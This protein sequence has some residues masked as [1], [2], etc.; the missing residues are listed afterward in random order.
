MKTIKQVNQAGSRITWSE[1]TYRLRG[2][3]YY[4][5]IQGYQSAQQWTSTH[6]LFITTQGHGTL[7]LDNREYSL[8]RDC[9]YWFVP[10]HT[11]GLRSDA[12]D[13]IEAYLFYFD[14]YKEVE[15][16]A[17]LQPLR[18]EE[19]LE[20]HESIAVSSVGELA[21][22]CDA[23]VRMHGSVH[24]QERFRA[25]FAF[26]ELLYTLLNHTPLAMSEQSSPAIERAKAYMDL[27]YNDSLS[28]EQL[29]AIAG[30][31]PKYF[32]DLFKKTY[33]MSSHDYLTE[34]RMNKAKE[35][36]NRSGVKLRD[37]A[38]QVGYQD[39]FYFS[40]KFKQ[41]VGVSPSVYMRSRKRKIAAYG[42]GVAGYLL[43]L[44]IIPYA[45]P[46]HPK[47][48]KYY[49]DQYRY[50]IP[51]HLSAYRVNEHWA[52]NIEK[53]QEVS[54]D[55]IVTMDDL[56]R[57]EQEQLEQ[58]GNICSIPSAM[59]WRDQL[60]H[61]AKLLGE[62]SDAEN[63]LKRYDR[64]VNWI[65][66][67]LPLRVRNE[68][69]LF[70]RILRQQIFAYCNRGIAEVMF[71]SLQLKPAFQWK[72]PIYNV[73]MSLEQLAQIN[74]DRLLVNVCQESET[75]ASWQQLQESWR[76]QQLEAVR[77]QRMHMIHTDP[78]VE[79]SPIAM[80]RMME[81]MLELLSGKCP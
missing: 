34:L 52:A 29:G 30:V 75:L 1:A 5:Q 41:V 37:I 64:R 62:D 66:E 33:G 70:V 67:Q 58:M 20:Q 17:Q 28:I 71:G 3:E 59:N 73:E 22:H 18:R 68:S 8:S 44:N 78:W 36:L 51:V 14:M 43:A 10:E 2:A 56:I 69:L 27:H 80:E 9:A 31:S 35:F 60:K 49:Y 7:Q 32:V 19:E 13:G 23:V 81:T 4:K 38:H 16:E 72:E 11:F 39:E 61:T 6:L 48:T 24:A 76:W 57:E 50:D 40:R 79:Y 21:L 65:R 53:L 46:L 45:A 54:P 26:Q 25:Q 55:I 47:W 12:E 77:H 42:T 15:G 63:W 74:P